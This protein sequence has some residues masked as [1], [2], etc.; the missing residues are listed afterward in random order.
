M[1]RTTKI[2]PLLVLVT[3]LAAGSFG[4]SSPAYS[5]ATP[6]LQ[7]SAESAR[8]AFDLL[9]TEFLNELGGVRTEIEEVLTIKNVP[10]RSTTFN[11]LDLMLNGWI[12]GAYGEYLIQD[13]SRNAQ[14]ATVK[15]LGRISVLVHQFDSNDSSWPL[16]EALNAEWRAIGTRLD[17]VPEY[18]D[19]SVAYHV[20]GAEA[21]ETVSIV[22]IDRWVV[23]VIGSYLRQTKPSDSESSDIG[24]LWDRYLFPAV[25]HIVGQAVKATKASPTTPESEASEFEQEPV[26]PVAH[27]DYPGYEHS[28]GPVQYVEHPPVGGV[29]DYEWYTCQ[30][31]DVILRSENAVHSLEHG[32]VW[33]TFDS[34]LPDEQKALIKSITEEQGYILASPMLNLPAPVVASSWNNQILLE[35]ADDPDLRRFI[36]IYKQGPDTPEIGA[37]CTGITEPGGA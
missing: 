8:S 31:Y 22:Q 29:H 12:D 7:D 15:G 21:S 10:T 2:L 35:G 20:D 4:L 17:S 24:L 1:H 13:E 6:A 28:D 26:K 33:I 11:I 23:E 37:S 36:A 25:E 16:A 3:V 30:Y 27:F 18:G 9:P 5:Q 32:A 34:G 19:V 14:T